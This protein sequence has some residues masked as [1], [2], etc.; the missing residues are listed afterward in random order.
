MNK[1]LLLIP[2][3]VCPFLGQ[4]CHEEPGALVE[5]SA[6]AIVGVLLDDLPA[7]PTREAVA[8]EVLAQTDA[9]WEARAIRQVQ[10]GHYYRGTYTRYFYIDTGTGDTGPVVPTGQIPYPPE[11]TWTITLTGTA[12]RSTIDGHDYITVPYVFD[13]TLLTSKG[14]PEL[15]VKT[16]G[17][18][19]GSYTEP[20]VW[21][22]D[23]LLVFQR[24]GNACVDEVEYPPGSYDPEGGWRFYDWTCTNDGT[25]P[26]CHIEPAETDCLT[27]LDT[28]VGKIDVGMTFTRVP[29][30][31]AT[32]D[33]VRV[34]TP[35]VEGADLVVRE[36]MLAENRIR[37]RYIPAGSCELE[38]LCV[39]APGWRKLL[40]FSSQN[41][42]IGATDLHLGPVQKIVDDGRNLYHLSECHG[43]YHLQNYGF[44]SFTTPDGLVS[45]G[46]KQGFALESTNRLSNNEA[47]P[48]NQFY[49]IASYQGI[50]AGHADLYQQGIPCQWVDVTA[51]DTS[52][53]E[54]TGTLLSIAN[55]D[56]LLC[57]GTETID[58][59]G[60]IT[61]W[62]MT[63]VLDENGDP[64][65]RPVCDT[66]KSPGAELNNEGSVEAVVPVNGDGF[67]TKACV[68]GE[69]GPLR[70]C[71]LTYVDSFDC[72]AGS[73]V[74]YVGSSTAVLPVT[75]ICQRSEALGGT[76]CMF[77]EAV[78]QDIATTVTFECPPMLDS[79]TGAGGYSVYVGDGGVL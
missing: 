69:V 36:D 64:I 60:N 56:G 59:G 21:P 31:K 43:H 16:L 18:I 65:Q 37:Y 3:A 2:I 7:G 51:V 61:A 9:F 5:V 70:D 13:G 38:E 49:D 24:T 10:F 67:V 4:D 14:S 77:H 57:E 12:T 32:A 28:Y 41:Q 63:S 76:A 34:D 55:P 74:T 46:H 79:T 23:P 48:M 71:G 1:L 29:W 75:R 62:E 42:N 40:E 26:W 52:A 68:G 8:A 54:V 58:T 11:E 25:T 39:D 66:S 27:A 72:T 33:A 78:S 45:L 35:T 53:G 44:Y 47:T 50:A 73:T 19:G 15:S 22:I 30:N 17:T 20:E 6:T